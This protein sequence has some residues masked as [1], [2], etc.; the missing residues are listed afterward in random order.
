M[1][2]TEAERAEIVA[3]LRKAR[4][5]GKNRIHVI[6]SRGGWHVFREGALKGGRAFLAKDQA[7]A[8][9][10]DRAKRLQSELVIHT[11][12]AEVETVESFSK[13]VPVV[14]SSGLQP[15]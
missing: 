15:G 8:Y 14:E 6:T 10:R 13:S 11:R 2:F 3:L 4:A 12:D 5:E 7:I 1:R 9:G